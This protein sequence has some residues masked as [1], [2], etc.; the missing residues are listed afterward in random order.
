MFMGI[1]L[2][3][4][5][6]IL[7]IHVSGRVGDSLYATPA[8]MAIREAYP[9]CK[10]S[11]LAHKNRLELFQNMPGIYLIGSISNKRAKWKG[12]FTLKKYDLVIVFN[13]Q[14]ELLD[15]TRY[16]LRVGKKTIAYK[17]SDEKIND[18]LF[19]G[20][21]PCPSNH[22][23]NA[24]P[25]AQGFLNIP[26]AMGIKKINQRIRF[27]PTKEEINE[28][29]SIIAK[30][31][32]GKG[33]F[34][35]AYQIISFPTRAYR[36]WPVKNYITL[37]K[38]IISQMPNAHF[39]LFGSNE[40]RDKVQAV[41]N[42]LGNSRCT[43]LTGLSLRLTAAIMTKLNLYIGVNTGPTI[44]M[45]AFNVPL[46]ALYHGLLPSK[47]CAP[48]CF[49][50]SILIDHPKGSQCNE[51]S[52]MAEISVDKVFKAVLKTLN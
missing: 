35:I 31:S 22:S 20:L 32:T 26:M 16:T 44:M 49:N 14:E 19:I 51:H 29:Q 21:K 45:S 2:N 46:I 24:E 38:K 43:N 48:K 42:T 10:I 23:A 52:S 9:N 27:F 6:Q 41:Q 36:D 12:W 34:L 33:S 18:K 28:A 37:S 8:I 47:L 11:L 15:I 40:D 39:L 30:Y 50:K 7:I 1:N 13:H 4:N 3:N 17:T 25:I 5:S